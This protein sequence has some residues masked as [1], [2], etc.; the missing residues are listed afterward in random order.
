M[1][2]KGK[3]VG[4]PAGA[5]LFP[6]FPP[7]LASMASSNRQRWA[8]P[9]PVVQWANRRWGPFDIDLAAEESTAKCNQFISPGEDAL[10]PNTPWGRPR[11]KATRAWLNPPWNNIDPFMERVIE[12]VYTERSL[13]L[14]CVLVPTRTGRPWWSECVER[15]GQVKLITGDEGRSSRISFIPPP[16]VNDAGGGFEDAAYVVFERPLRLYQDIMVPYGGG[17]PCP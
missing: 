17:T 8:T 4:T 5:C 3:K 14:I 2:E 16:G 1:G 11:R 15:Y 6:P 9:W 7:F 12:E 10:N 13:D